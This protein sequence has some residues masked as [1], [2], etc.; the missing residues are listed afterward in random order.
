MSA[1][2]NQS[3]EYAQR[4]G[5]YRLL[6]LLGEGG[7]GSVWLAEQEHPIRRQVALKLIKPGMDSCEVVARFESEGQALAR[8]NHPNIAAVYDAGT[9]PQ[10]RPYFAMEYVPGVPITAFCDNRRLNIH[11]RLELLMAVCDA[12]HH[13]HQ[14]GIIHRDL[15]PSNILVTTP[16]GGGEAAPRCLPKVIDFGLAKAMAPGESVAV[17]EHRQFVGTLPYASPEQVDLSQDIDTRTDGR[18]IRPRRRDVT[19]RPSPGSSI[20]KLAPSKRLDDNGN[21]EA[22]TVFSV[23]PPG[24]AEISELAYGP[25]AGPYTH[26]DAHYERAVG[27]HG[28]RLPGVAA[29]CRRIPAARTSGPHASDDR[30]RA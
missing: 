12:V 2:A 17:T 6:K 23:P 24:F 9:N 14:K 4:I 1:T 22:Q 19:A 13:A 18:F 25:R 30:A 10:D 11:Q 15:K 29:N 27:P 3:G 26:G 28:S 8:L 21:L 5:A 7:M 20:K 16:E